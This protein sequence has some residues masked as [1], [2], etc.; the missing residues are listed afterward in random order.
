MIYIQNLSDTLG[1]INIHGQDSISFLQGQLTND[2]NL[3]NLQ[4]FQYSAYLNNKGRIIA[5]FIIKQYAVDNYYL[6]TDKNILDMVIARFK[7]YVMRS[8]VIIQKLSYSISFNYL[9]INDCDDYELLMCKKDRVVINLIDNYYL[10]ILTN[11][12]ECLSQNIT[13]LSANIDH[14]IY[15][16]QQF[17]IN[18]RIV[19]IYQITQEKVIP[20]FINYDNLQGISY[21][22]GCYIGQEIVA[23][24]HYLGKSNRQLYKF[25]IKNIDKLQYATAIG[26]EVIDANNNSQSVGVILELTL[27]VDEINYIGLITLPSGN[28]D[29]LYLD[30]ALQHQIYIAST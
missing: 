9:S 11:D 4:N 3:L 18:Y 12:D 16:W 24:M 5:T 7:M 26:S 25:T 1:I 17:L 27:D 14:V 22:K 23:R 30:H 10:S 29:A 19:I 6:I 15:S 28:F 21:T 13:S 20:Q 2:I 8:K